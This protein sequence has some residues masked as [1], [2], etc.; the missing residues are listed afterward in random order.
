[1]PLAWARFSTSCDVVYGKVTS[2]VTLADQ[3]AT[4][5]RAHRWFS[6]VSPEA[7]VKRKFSP[8]RF[9][10]VLPLIPPSPLLL[11]AARGARASQPHSIEKLIDPLRVD[12]LAKMSE[13]NA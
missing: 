7:F 12:E 3:T 8:T 10:K 13:V 1:M 5:G 11:D 6:P 4:T 9:P 2:S